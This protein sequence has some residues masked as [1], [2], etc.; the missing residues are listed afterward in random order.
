MSMKGL[1]SV[2]VHWPGTE[3]TWVHV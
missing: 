2:C 1:A 3:P